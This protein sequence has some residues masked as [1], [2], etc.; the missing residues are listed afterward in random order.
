MSVPQPVRHGDL[1]PEVVAEQQQRLVE[2]REFHAAQVDAVHEDDEVSFI[3]SRRS[4]RILEDID[5]ALIAITHGTYGACETCADHI[6]L[7]RLE[8][9]PHTR[10]CAGCVSGR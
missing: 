9:I 1:A 8:A 5:R 2:A 6:P 7:E 10:Q 3:V 4:E